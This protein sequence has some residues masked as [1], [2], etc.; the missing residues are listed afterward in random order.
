MEE[1][2]LN[3]NGMS[4]ENRQ[5]L[6]AFVSAHEAFAEVFIND[7]NNRVAQAQAMADMEVPD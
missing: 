6:N 1:L 3:L 2:S 7:F 4:N 5:D